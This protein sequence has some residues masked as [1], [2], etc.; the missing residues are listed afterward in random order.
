MKKISKKKLDK[1][2]EWGRKYYKATEVDQDK[3]WEHWY[4]ARTK[5]FRKNERWLTSILSGLI[6]RR[7]DYDE[8]NETF[9]KVLEALG[10][11]IVEG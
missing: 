5:L 11:E 7:N 3:V 8:P 9:Y 4:N 10:F 2:I 6:I 1:V